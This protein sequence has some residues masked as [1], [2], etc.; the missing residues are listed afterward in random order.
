MLRVYPNT[1]KISTVFKICIRDHVNADVL[2]YKSFMF[3][4]PFNQTANPEETITSNLPF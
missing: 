2:L 4:C 1:F 3:G